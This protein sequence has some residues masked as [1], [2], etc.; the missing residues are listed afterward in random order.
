MHVLEIRRQIKNIQI[1][2]FTRGEKRETEGVTA[3]SVYV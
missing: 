2:G 1:V 3:A